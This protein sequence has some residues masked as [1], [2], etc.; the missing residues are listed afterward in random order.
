MNRE[1]YKR[2]MNQ[3]I[4]RDLLDSDGILLLKK[5]SILTESM[6]SKLNV[7]I[8]R[9]EYVTQSSETRQ[10]YNRLLTGTVKEVREIF[11]KVKSNKKEINRIELTI[12]P[13]VEELAQEQ[14]LSLLLEGILGKD[15]YTYRHNIGV[16]ILSSMLAR[17]LHFSE[18]DI[19]L[20]T[21]GG[22]L[23]DIGKIQV[24][25]YILTKPGR[26]TKEEYEAIQ[27]HP[28]YGYQILKEHSTYSEVIR[29]MALE[30]HEREDGSGYPHQKMAD[31]IHPFSKII[32]VADVFHAM[33]SDRVYRRGHA[34]YDVLKQMKEDAFGKLEPS[35]VYTF[36]QKLMELSIGN[37]AIL[38]NGQI[39]E[40]VFIYPD[41]PFNPLVR[42]NEQLIDLRSSELKMK[43]LLTVEG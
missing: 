19:Q 15:D 13:T 14:R 35:Y 40:V 33:T 28:S 32:A 23:H 31:D 22:L 21:L 25:D 3:E 20:V 11:R 34:L 41:E 26:L 7:G 8:D 42:C 39:V 17:W 29:L 1:L 30:H 10:G 2:Y 5:G 18:S 6:L 27:Q 4:K 36:I 43:Q 24:D 38:S 12:L 37:Q 16:A 9:I